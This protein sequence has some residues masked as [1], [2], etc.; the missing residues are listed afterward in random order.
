MSCSS[1]YLACMYTSNSTL[2]SA[3]GERGLVVVIVLVQVV[4][5]ILIRIP[6]LVL[7]VVVVMDLLLVMIIIMDFVDVFVGLG[8]LWWSPAPALTTTAMPPMVDL[9]SRTLTPPP[10]R[11][12]G[13]FPPTPPTPIPSAVHQWLPPSGAEEQGILQLTNKHKGEFQLANG[14][15]NS[16]LICLIMLTAAW[17]PSPTKRTATDAEIFIFISF[18]GVTNLFHF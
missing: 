11:V 10:M 9:H 8:H 15:H 14:I 5:L 13:G 16:Q 1:Q 3:S 18:Q 17:N 12:G 7:V 2:S 6:Y 4:Y